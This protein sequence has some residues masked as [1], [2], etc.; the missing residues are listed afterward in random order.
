MKN[1]IYIV[2]LLFLASTLLVLLE[3]PIAI[4][5]KFIELLGVGLVMVKF[6]IDYYKNKKTHPQYLKYAIYCGIAFII[7]VGAL[8]SN[9]KVPSQITNALLMLSMLAFVMV[10]VADGLYNYKHVKNGQPKKQALIY[11]IIFALHGLVSFAIAS[12]YLKGYDILFLIPGIIVFDIIVMIPFIILQKAYHQLLLLAMITISLSL[13]S[14]LL[15]RTVRYSPLQEKMKRSELSIY[16]GPEYQGAC[17]LC[18]M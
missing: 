15:F 5:I 2:F 10:G 18:S 8:F 16:K 1:L 7:F 4:R 3:L 9:T 14:F 17:Y 6:A 12:A 13:H 11:L